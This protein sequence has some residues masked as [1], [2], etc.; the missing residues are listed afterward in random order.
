MAKFSI[1]PEQ[2]K[3][4][5]RSLGCDEIEKDYCEVMAEPLP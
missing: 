3:S 5:G 2:K 1:P 4:P